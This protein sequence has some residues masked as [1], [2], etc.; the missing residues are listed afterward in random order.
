MWSE[1]G[2]GERYFSRTLAEEGPQASFTGSSDWRTFELPFLLEGGAS[3][4]RLEIDVVLP[5][6]G[7][8]ELG[9]IEIVPLSGAAEAW[10]S[11]RAAGFVGGTLGAAIGIFGALIGWLVA[12]RRARGFVLAA[13]KVCVMIGAMCIAVGLAAL[14]MSQPYAVVYP[15]VLTGTILAVVFGGLFSGAKRAYADR[16][17]RRMRAMDQA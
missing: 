8:V 2:H 6:A 15:L 5:G 12:R 9:P 11:D 13:M 17:L 3:P 1:F 10:W 16:E 4:V 14:G 7:T